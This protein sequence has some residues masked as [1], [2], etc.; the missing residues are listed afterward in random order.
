MEDKTKNM[1]L[2]PKLVKNPK[3][4]VTKKNGGNVPKLKDPRCGLVPIGCQKCIECKKQKGRAWSIRLQEEI[5]HDKTGK[6]VTLTFSNEK[7]RELIRA[8]RVVDKETGELLYEPEGY[9]LDNEIATL[10]VRRIS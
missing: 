1:C 6:F 9:E 7:I 2:Y 8:L 4:T 10:G 3:Y 5:K